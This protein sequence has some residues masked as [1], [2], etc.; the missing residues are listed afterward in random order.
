M[1][2]SSRVLAV[3]VALVSVVLSLPSLAQV[4]VLTHHNDNARTGQNLSE[5]YLTRAVVNTKQFGELFTQAVDGMVVAQP[6][7][8][9]NLQINGVTHNV[10]FVVTLHDGIFAFDA[11]SNTGNNAEPLWY[12]S[13]I[14]PPKVTTVPIA[15]QGC[16]PGF[17]EVGIVGTPVIDPST[18]TMYLVAK[19]LE[20][21]EYVHRLHALDV[22]TGQEKFGGP[23]AIKASYDSDGK[24]VTFK[25]RHR[26][27]RA[28]LLLSHGVIYIAFGTPGCIGHP[29]STAWM[30]AYSAS[31]LKKLAVLDLG[32]TQQS[33][34]GMWMS[35]DGPSVDSSGDVYVATGEGFFDYNVGGLDYG[36]TLLKLSLERQQL[37]LVDYFTP[38]NQAELYHNDLDLGSSGLVILPHQQGQYPHLGIIAGKQGMIYLVNRDNLGQYNSITDQVVQEEPFDPDKEVEI[39]GG[40]TYWNNLV[41][42]GAEGQ[43]VKAFSLINGVLSSGPVAT[44][45]AVHYSRSVFSISA[46][47][48]EDGI[49]WALE[50]GRGKH[51]LDAYNASNLKLLYSSTQNPVRD[52]I[53]PLTHFA[54]PTIANGKVYV[55][56]TDNLVVM[57]LLHKNAVSRGNNQTGQVATHPR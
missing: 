30:M 26:M 37:W 13:L 50:I 32:P 21:G 29:P 20:S 34:P 56:T 14:D 18:N 24:E 4:S 5:P 35:G 38:Y 23:V 55:G 54:L 28:A 19:T 6:L 48:T 47:G 40:A 11:D 31:S 41:Y 10:V 53:D 42:F 49:L 51:D 57:G 44:T 8:V 2:D 1:R 52:P 16:R 43:P 12:K 33:V 9:P 15:D 27:Q 3:C 17:T 22:T 25:N 7:Y 36:D 45:S 39:Y 46:N